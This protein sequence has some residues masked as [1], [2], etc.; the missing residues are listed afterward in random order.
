MTSL[1]EGKDMSLNK[2][3]RNCVMTQFPA[4][5]LNAPSFF[6]PDASNAA[7]TLATVSATI[8]VLLFLTV[9]TGTAYRHFFL[10]AGTDIEMCKLFNFNKS[11]YDSSTVAQI[12]ERFEPNTVLCA[13]HIIAYSHLVFT[14]LRS[15][16]AVLAT[17][18]PSVC[19]SVCHTPVLCQNAGT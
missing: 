2:I 10:V 12:V 17:A 8:P 5:L 14:A 11:L 19:P 1:G 7:M 18:I 4:F 16:S 6:S 15:A 13:F 9:R 3:T